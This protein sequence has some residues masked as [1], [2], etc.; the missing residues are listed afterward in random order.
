MNFYLI[1]P[2]FELFTEMEDAGITGTLLTYH[3]KESDYFIKVARDIDIHKK[4]KYMIAIRPHLISPEYLLRLIKGIKEISK[5]NRL[6]IN[7]V[8][9][10]IVDEEYE[11]DRILGPITNKST[12]EE[13]SDYLIQ[14]IK[15]LNQLPQ[16]EKPDYYVSATNDFTIEAASTYNDK[17][18]IPYHKYINEKH[19]LKDKKVMVYLSPIL[20]KTQEEL[21][22]LIGYNVEYI[23]DVKFT[24]EEMSR[25]VNKLK[26][27]G[28]KEMMLSAWNKED[29]KINIQFI[30]EYNYS[31]GK[32]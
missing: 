4:I 1:N 25:L 10:A 20:R 29:L 18:M 2:Y 27:E 17:I 19:N 6:Q 15:L 32:N 16:D 12:K 11:M 28:I 3:S 31:K 23:E 8:S 9:G 5:G 21:D 14:Y 30:K 22:N 7:L 13:R 24:Y 26:E